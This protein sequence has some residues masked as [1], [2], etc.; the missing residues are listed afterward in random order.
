MY[1]NERTPAPALVEDVLQGLGLS[2]VPEPDHAGLARVYAAWC[3]RVPFDNV[4]KL[5]HLHARDPGPLPGDDPE[6]FF[7]GWLKHGTG[8]TC[9]AGNGALHALLV[10]LGFDARRGLATMLAAPELPPNH[11]T[12]TV[13]IDGRRYLVDAS[14]LHGEPLE[15]KE[16]ESSRV[17]H[18]AWGVACTRGPDGW[19]IRWR[20]THRPDGMD[21]RIDSLEVGRDEF[22]ERHELTRAWSPFNYEL[23]LRLI[24]GEGVIGIGFGGRVGF[25]HAGAVEQEPLD[26]HARNRVLREDFGLSEEIVARL[27]PDSETPPP[28]GSRAAANL[29]RPGAEDATAA[30]PG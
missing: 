26:L 24:R 17:D 28:P 3:R 10:S 16:F 7:V 6:D 8:G 13:A 29:A 2:G 15:L 30:G 1:G 22:C 4:R 25:G 11:G 5:I 21:C 20:P 27:P 23:N 12:V 9:W 19:R 14:I 18:P